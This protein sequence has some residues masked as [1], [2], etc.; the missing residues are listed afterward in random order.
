MNKQ[1]SKQFH[2]NLSKFN[3]GVNPYRLT[4][5]RV[6]AKHE[7]EI[8]QAINKGYNQIQI[9]NALRAIEGT[10]FYREGYG[11]LTKDTCVTYVR[12]ICDELNIRKA[13]F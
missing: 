10:P 5:T 9:A 1:Q 7:K 4:G 12:Q 6:L 2:S 13:N 11:K 3:V 8:R